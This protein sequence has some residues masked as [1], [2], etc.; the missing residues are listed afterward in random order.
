MRDTWTTALCPCGVMACRRS[1]APPVRRMVGR[2]LGRLTTSMSRQNTPWLRPGPESLGAGLLG[3]EAPGIGWRAGG[4]AVAPRPLALGVD[5]VGEAVPE[6]LDGL[7][8]APN[9][10]EIGPDPEDH[11]GTCARPSS[12]AAR[13]ARTASSRPKKIASPIREWPILSSTICG[14]AATGADRVE[15]KPV[16]RMNLETDLGAVLGSPAQALEF[17]GDPGLVPV[18]HRLAIGAGVEFDHGSLEVA[19]RVHDLDLRLHEQRHPDALA[20]SAP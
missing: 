8:D 11:A 17:V 18:D 6:A 15:G 10:A 5:A 3:G 20:S 7:L 19:G 16:P 2:P 13:M 9:V 14:I 4:A 12:M 1:S